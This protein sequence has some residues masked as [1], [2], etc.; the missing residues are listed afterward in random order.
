MIALAKG[1]KATIEASL[2]LFMWDRI[3]DHYVWGIES[4]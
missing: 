4:K 2:V 1:R 3:E